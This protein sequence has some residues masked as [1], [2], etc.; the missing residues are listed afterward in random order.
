MRGNSR[1][2]HGTGQAVELGN[3]IIEDGD[4]GPRLPGQ[5][6]PR[7]AVLRLADDLVIGLGFQQLANAAA[8]SVVIVDNDD[9][10]DRARHGCP[11]SLLS[12]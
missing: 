9:P 10:S 11:A 4:V 1:L 5:L 2:R 12:T 7:P 8:D 3:R 6:E